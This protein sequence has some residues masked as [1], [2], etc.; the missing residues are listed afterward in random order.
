VAATA[1]AGAAFAAVKLDR[2]E[3][4]APPSGPSAPPSAP[5]GPG[6]GS[7]SASNG[8]D[9][10]TDRAPTDGSPTA[11]PA[12][13]TGD[14]TPS[15]KDAAQLPG[16]CR[17]YLAKSAD[18][19]ARALETP[20]YGPL[21]TDAGGPEKVADYCQRLVAD[22]DPDKKSPDAPRSAK[23]PVDGTDSVGFDTGTAG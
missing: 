4:P 6:S 9:T 12:P 18:Q 11:A 5:A 23:N 20:G 16:L 3:E 2:P 8:V 10:P 1:T 22:N 14:P 15:G 19:R 21:V 13:P 17:A 7:A